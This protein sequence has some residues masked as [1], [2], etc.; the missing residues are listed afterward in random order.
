MEFGDEILLKLEQYLNDTMDDANRISFETEIAASAQLQEFIAIYNR[1]DALEDDTAWSLSEHKGDKLKEVLRR[2]QSEETKAFS[3]KIK[4]FRTEEQPPLANSSNLYKTALFVMMAAC[5]AFLVYVVIPNEAD[6]A[7]LYIENSTWEELPSLVVKGD[8]KN[9]KLA[10]E[11]AFKAGDYQ[12]A[13]N[14]SNTILISSSYTQADMLLYKGIAHLEMNEYEDALTS[15]N[16]LLASDHIDH[17]KGYWYNAMVYL[18]KGE[19]NKTI[20]ALKEVTSDATNYQYEQATKLL[21]E[22]D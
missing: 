6:M 20:S 1:I 12:K 2:F 19:K 17:H 13:V 16:L 14:L 5:M 4:L 21:K 8:D 9:P 22:L 18:K 7:S 15:F 10:V 3:A 11:K